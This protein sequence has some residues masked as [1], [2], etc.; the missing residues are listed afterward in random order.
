VAVLAIRCHLSLLGRLSSRMQTSTDFNHSAAT[1]LLSD[2]AYLAFSPAL[3]TPPPKQSSSWATGCPPCAMRAWSTAATRW[4]P[5][6]ASSWQSWVGV[7]LGGCG[8]PRLLGGRL[9]VHKRL[10][11][12]PGCKLTWLE[13]R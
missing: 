3:P 12:T 10:H 1:V 9:A 4:R 2:L 13:K 7:P 11:K 6:A 8:R 5:W